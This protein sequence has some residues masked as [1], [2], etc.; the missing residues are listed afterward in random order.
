MTNVVPDYISSYDARLFAF[1]HLYTLRKYNKKG[2]KLDYKELLKNIKQGKLY[3][4]GEYP[5]DIDKKQI[6]LD[7]ISEQFPQIEW[8]LNKKGNFD[9]TN[10]DGADSL[11]CILGYLNKEKYLSEKPVLD[12][13]HIDEKTKTISY[14]TRLPSVKIAFEHKLIY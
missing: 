10:F 13:V 2:T 3:M 14:K 11:C 7:N 6:V 12:H 1:P 8:T 4:F 5:L 9:K